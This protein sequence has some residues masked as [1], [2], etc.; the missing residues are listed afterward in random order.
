MRTFDKIVENL[1]EQKSIADQLH[2]GS[3]FITKSCGFDKNSLI[4]SPTF[5]YVMPLQSCSESVDR[6]DSWRIW[7]CIRLAY[8]IRD[9]ILSSSKI[10]I[11]SQ[12]SNQPLKQRWRRAYDGQLKRRGRYLTRREMKCWQKVKEEFISNDIAIDNEM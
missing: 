11:T 8:L 1:V 4:C 5:F 6:G 7:S 9:S 10:S 12:Q 2:D 3:K